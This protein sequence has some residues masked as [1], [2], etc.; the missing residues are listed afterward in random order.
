LAHRL[1]DLSRSGGAVLGLDGTLRALRRGQARLLLARDGFAKMGY[2]CPRCG[3]LSLGFSRCPACNAAMA[4][5][6]NIVE[7]MIQRA[8][9]AHCEVI[10]LLNDSVLDGMG[11]IGAELSGEG[12]SIRPAPKPAAA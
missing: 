7:E 9:D 4:V 12:I 10:R 2:L 3:E 8:L 6:F 1:L 11:H 5:I